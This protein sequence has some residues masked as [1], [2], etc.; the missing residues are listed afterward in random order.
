[1][2]N[3]LINDLIKNGDLKS[4]LVIDAF[5][6][7]SRIEFVPVEL[8]LQAEKNI[9]LPVG[10]GRLITKPETTAFILEMLDPQ[11]GQK[12]LVIESGSGWE[13]TMLA[14]IVGRTGRV[15]AI[16]RNNEIVKFSENNAN[17]FS[18]IKDGTLSFF[19]ADEMDG[20][21]FEAPYDRILVLAE[22][23]EVPQKFKDQLKV[24]GKLVMAVKSSLVYVE[25]KS[26]TEFSEEE[27]A[28]FHFPA[29]SP[30]NYTVIKNI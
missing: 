6:D 17:K 13:A 22:H 1:M 16:D 7:I 19:C 18:F 29:L 25:K 28:G 12:I 5:S 10:F 23:Y 3:S 26:E 9:S 21:A 15:V 27:F 4:D 14:L 30:E 11:I 20:Y 2:M 8:E 24:G